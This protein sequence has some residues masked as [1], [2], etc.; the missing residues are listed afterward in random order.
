LVFDM[1]PLS[2]VFKAGH[3]IRLIIS[4]VEVP[5][6]AG[7]APPTPILSP[8]P[9]VTFYRDA[10]HASY[11]QMPLHAPLDATVRIVADKSGKST[12]YISFPKS[13]D[14]RYLNDI[15]PGSVQWNGVAATRTRREGETLVAEFGGAATVGS[16]VTIQ[17][18][19]GGKY[20]YGDFMSFR[21]IGH[22]AP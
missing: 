3:R 2:W 15:T 7:A 1:A 8:P 20:Y 13:L 14:S 6:H 10:A 12:A 5:R 4:C 16:E 11:I 18:R 17:G 22:L 19:F 21:G 9:I